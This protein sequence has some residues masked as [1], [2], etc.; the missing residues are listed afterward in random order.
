MNQAEAFAILGIP[1]DAVARGRDAA[2]ITKAYR[3]ASLK[4]HPDKNENS[5][6]STARFQK[7]NEAY[8]YL[9]SPASASASASMPT[10]FAGA[11]SYQEILVFFIRTMFARTGNDAVDGADIEAALM[12][13]V[14]SNYDKL[15]KTLDK[16][17]AVAVYEFMHEYADV[18]HLPEDT[19]EK[20]FK[21]VSDKM[22]ADNLVILNPTLSD[23]FQKKVY[24]LEYESKRFKVPLW[25]N[26]VYYSL[27]SESDL[28][29]RCNICDV[30]NYMYID[31]NNHITLSIRTSIQRL[32][33]T[34][35]VTVAVPLPDQPPVE[36]KIPSHALVITTAPQL[37]VCPDPAIGIP[38]INTRIPLDASILA[39]ISVRVELY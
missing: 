10:S 32:L 11:F 21:I 16:S 39:G 28:V 34:G 1:P 18:L 24:E 23:V 38:K 37:Y 17:T 5:P 9:S 14:S 25:H 26:E 3:V 29:V 20:M 31:E 33:D 12:H 19:L 35:S 22:K 15:L 27:T 30:P 8:H 36:I 6:E 13:I 4:H 2:Y 7:I